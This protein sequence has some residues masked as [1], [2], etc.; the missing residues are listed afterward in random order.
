MAH[1]LQ[2]IVSVRKSPH[3]YDLAVAKRVYVCEA[4]VL[5]F[6]STSSEH[7]CVNEH[8]DSVSRGKELLGF[9]DHLGY[10]GA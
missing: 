7:S 3:L 5:P 1:P 10:C 4:D 8:H 2:G 6:G 9:A